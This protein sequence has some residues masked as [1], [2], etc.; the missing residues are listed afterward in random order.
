MHTDII[1]VAHAVPLPDSPSPV[2]SPMASA[3][4]SPASSFLPSPSQYEDLLRRFE[5][6]E[7]KIDRL[8][9]VNKVKKERKVTDAGKLKKARFNYYHHYKKDPGML[10]EVKRRLVSCNLLKTKVKDGVV[11]DDIPWTLIKQITDEE[12]NKLSDIDKLKWHTC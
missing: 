11:V 7:I 9:S 3:R 1:T 6:L 10:E 5:A 4:T 2:A 8:A 12:F